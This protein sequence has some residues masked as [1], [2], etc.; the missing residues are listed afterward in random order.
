[1]RATPAVAWGTKTLTNP[2]PCPEQKRSSSLREV[3]DALP[4]G[5]DVQLRL[6]ASIAHSAVACRRAA[7]LPGSGDDTVAAIG[8]R[9]RPGGRGHRSA[10]GQD[11][12][13]IVGKPPRLHRLVRADEPHAV[14]P[15]R[16]RERPGTAVVRWGMAHALQ[17]HDGHQGSPARA[18]RR[19]RF[20]EP[21]SAHWTAPRVIAQ[22]GASPDIVRSPS[23]HLRRHLSDA[24]R[25]GLPYEQRRVPAVMVERPPARTRAGG[26]HD[27]W[28]AG[29][30]RERG[31]SRVQ[32]RND[33]ATLRDRL[34]AVALRHVSSGGSARHCAVRRHRRELRVRDR[35]RSVAPRGDVEHARPALHFHAGTG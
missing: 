11:H 28:C 2:S 29:L 13:C 14:V 32:G 18:L 5:I 3:D 15:R 19:V 27:R 10:P 33:H 21:R 31:D 9:G 12:A 8:G 23:G 20:V 17:R 22:N 34:G 25:T 24:A 7:P 6:S 26:P 35:R 4:R 1:M 16:R 30:H